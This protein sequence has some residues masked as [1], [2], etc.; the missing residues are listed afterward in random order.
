MAEKQI[1]LVKSHTDSYKI[2]IGDKLEGKIRF[3]CNKFPATEWSGILFWDIKGTFEENNIVISAKDFL[4]MDIGDATTTAFEMTPQVMSYMIDNNLV[5]SFIGLMHS[6]HSMTTFFSATDTNTLLAEGQNSNHFVSLIVN[7][8][9]TYS[10][11]ITRLIESEEKIKASLSYK[12]FG[13]KPVKYKEDYS[14][15]DK[16]V[17]YFPLIV[18]FESQPEL[19]SDLE[20]DIAEIKKKKEEEEKKKKIIMPTLGNFGKAKDTTLFD[21]HYEDYYRSTYYDDPFLDE[22]IMM[23]ESKS[24]VYDNTVKCFCNQLLKGSPFAENSDLDQW[25]KVNMLQKFK[26]RFP[27]E[28][29]FITYADYLI[30]FL[31]EDFDLWENMP[32]LQAIISDL[33]FLPQNIYIKNYIEILKK[34]LHGI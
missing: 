1:L 30:E 6:H 24:T 34:Y 8:A 4:L 17:E 20:K 14:I 33:E 26:K 12:S 22:T 25:I 9:G 31:I 29:S 32:I 28:G 21:Q 23:K 16:Y 7:N 2:I 10:A 5:G 19:Y 15:V 11:A 27:H 13:D 18:E 3:L